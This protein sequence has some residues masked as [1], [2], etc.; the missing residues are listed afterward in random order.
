MHFLHFIFFFLFPHWKKGID[1][2]SL[3]VG[4]KITFLTSIILQ[5]YKSR[6]SKYCYILF[7]CFSLFFSSIGFFWLCLFFFPAISPLL[8]L[9]PLFS[10][11]SGGVVISHAQI[12]FKCSSLHV[13][14]SRL[15]HT[16]VQSS[17]I[18]YPLSMI[19]RLTFSSW[20]EI[21]H[22]FQCKTMCMSILH[23][24]V[25]IWFVK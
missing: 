4:Q 21:N 9:G 2:R 8:W 11:T 14:T 17:D 18:K 12:I 19:T 13:K 20:S 3:W 22:I 15:L 24:H 1:M 16:S 6:I 23:Q 10:F 7:Y 25:F 5:N